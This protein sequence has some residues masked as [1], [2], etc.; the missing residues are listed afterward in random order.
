VGSTPQGLAL[1]RC[2]FYYPV[3]FLFRLN[4]DLDFQKAKFD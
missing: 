2:I 4:A 3:V 1:Y